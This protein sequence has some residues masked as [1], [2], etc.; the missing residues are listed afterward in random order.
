MVEPVA[1]MVEGPRQREMVALIKSYSRNKTAALGASV[2]C[3]LLHPVAQPDQGYYTRI[4]SDFY[5]KLSRFF[6]L[7]F[8]FIGCMLPGMVYRGVPIPV[9]VL[10]MFCL[11]IT[12]IPTLLHCVVLLLFAFTPRNFCRPTQRLEFWKV[13]SGALCFA[14]HA[15]FVCTR[16]GTRGT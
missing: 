5:F 8:V 7:V 2:D 14:L 6:V 3:Q 16:S 15:I 11:G 4:P 12:K 1:R 9:V 10:C 13:C